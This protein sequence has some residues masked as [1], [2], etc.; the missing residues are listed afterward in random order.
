[1]SRPQPLGK[2]GYRSNEEVTTTRLTFGAKERVLSKI[3]FVPFIAGIIKSL[4][5]SV[6]L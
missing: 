2:I 3:L 4:S 1:M 6:I 5:L